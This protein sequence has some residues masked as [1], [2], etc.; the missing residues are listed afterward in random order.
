ME[1]EKKKRNKREVTSIHETDFWYSS[2]GM[3]D[4]YQQAINHERDFSAEESKARF[5]PF[6]GRRQTEVFDSVDRAN[7]CHTHS[8]GA[9]KTKPRLS[10]QHL[11][12]SKV[13]YF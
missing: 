1:G 4:I 5:Y 2:K 11:V 9:P 10:W 8:P 3:Y 13:S 6:D 7:A 12:S